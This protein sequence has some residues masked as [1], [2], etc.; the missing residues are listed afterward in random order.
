MHNLYR[1]TKCAQ[2]FIAT[3]VVQFFRFDL[4]FSEFIENFHNN[5]KLWLKIEYYNWFCLFR[6]GSQGNPACNENKLMIL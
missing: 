2:N 1:R 6:V 4:F 3:Y 5:F